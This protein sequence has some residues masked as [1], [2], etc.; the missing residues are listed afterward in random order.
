MAPTRIEISYRTIV[1]FVFFLLSL[2]F[3]YLIRAVIIALF[4]S[5]IMMSALNPLIRKL[6]NKKIPRIIAIIMTFVVILV[7]V[8]GIIASIVPPFIDQSRS[9]INQIPDLLDRYGGVPIDQ[10]VISTQLG[11]V[12]GN[13]ARFLIGTFSNLIALAT[14]FVLT[15]YLLFE[16]GNLH[17][18]LSIFF[19]SAQTETRAEEFINELEHQIGGWIRGQMALMI[20]IGVL[21][22][23]GLRILGISFALP[24]AIFAGLLEI[25]PSIGPIISAI[26][27]VLIGL[28]ISPVTGLATIA[29]YFLIQQFENTIIVPKVMQKAVGVRPL[30]IIIALMIGAKLAGVLG[31][32]LAVPSYV[33][34]K[35]I[36][37][38][39]YSSNRFRKS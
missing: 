16:R 1:F 5:L 35:V 25:I 27:A 31:A 33:V 6:E 37:A 36:V 38:E 21:T 8:S 24:L 17:R 34:L 3:L 7:I 12:P 4:I 39:L 10:Q 13:I 9:L 32:L 2:W 23:V 15:F 11:S 14:V 18:Y 20:I 30:I 22:Y 28:A 29:L 19:G 26:P